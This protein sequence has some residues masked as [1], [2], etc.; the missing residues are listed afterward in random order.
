MSVPPRAQDNYLL[1][2]MPT[3]EEFLCGG[4]FCHPITNCR[5][6]VKTK[7]REIASTNYADYPKVLYRPAEP[8][9]R[10][11]PCGIVAATIIEHPL[12]AKVESANVC[13]IPWSARRLIQ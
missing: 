4:R 10:M 9:R 11:E 3:P 5:R 6:I 8:P 7:V 2:E 1:V 13:L 12:C